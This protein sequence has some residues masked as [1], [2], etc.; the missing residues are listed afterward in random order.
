MTVTKKLSV[1]WSTYLFISFHSLRQCLLKLVN[2]KCE[3]VN[4]EVVFFLLLLEDVGHATVGCLLGPM[5]LW[6]NA[7]LDSLVYVVWPGW[8]ESVVVTVR[9]WRF[10]AGTLPTCT[11]AVRGGTSA[12][13]SLSVQWCS[14]CL[15]AGNII[16]VIGCGGHF[17]Q[18]NSLDWGDKLVRR[19]GLI[20]S[21]RSLGYWG[22]T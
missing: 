9:V 15:Q 6:E 21:G 1:Q 8:W 5:L 10:L 20:D 19:V 7:Q 4:V 14:T 11:I 3:L 13:R 17:R 2:L 12:H 18:R 16:G 22:A